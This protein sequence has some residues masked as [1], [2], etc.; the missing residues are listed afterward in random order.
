MRDLP[1]YLDV[2]RELELGLRAAFDEWRENVFHWSALDDLIYR[3]ETNVDK[4]YEWV[5]R[6]HGA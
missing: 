6:V 3:D 5:R 1:V 4:F 2:A